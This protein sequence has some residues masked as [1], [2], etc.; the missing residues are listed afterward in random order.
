MN[1][2]RVNILIPMAGAGSRFQN[3]GFR[4]PK[5]LIDV[6]GKPMIKWAM[7]SFDFLDRVLSYRL[8][9][10]IS[11]DDDEEHKLGKRLKGIFGKGI[12]LIIAKTPTR[13]QA[14]TCLLAERYIDNQEKLFIYNCDTY[15]RSKILDL[16][17]KEDPDA[18]IPCF[19]SRNPRYS[20]AKEGVNGFVREV[21]EKKA[22]S[23]FATTGMYYFKHGQDFVEAAKSILLGKKLT[24]KEF[25][26]GPCYNELI[27]KGKKIRAIMSEKNFILGTPRE[28]EKFIRRLD[29]LKL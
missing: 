24:N 23:N 16:I 13:G 28:L 22:I 26:V 12:I 2:G 9:F 1:I 14:E 29:S 4:E 17:V 21:A 7:E 10:I 5:P 20:Y 18:I 6:G 11:K 8:I 19:K 27:K 25:Y 15:S 3:A